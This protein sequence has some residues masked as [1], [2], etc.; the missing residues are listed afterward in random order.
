MNEMDIVRK[1][2][3]LFYMFRKDQLLKK[4]Q[5]SIMKN[6]D[7][8]VLDAIHLLKDGGLIKMNDV[9]S[10]F[11][12][13]PA[14]VSQLMKKYEKKGWIQRV[15]L[16]N[17]RRSVYIQVSEEA[18]VMMKQYEQHMTE[19]LVDFIEELGEEDANALIRILEKALDY[20]KKRQQL[21]EGEHHVE[22]R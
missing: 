17:D 9:S 13:T 3:H 1:L 14:A 2:T 5:K 19:L 22:I 10:Y 12:V 8:M 7:I 4:D 15:E 18:L 21:K 20:S 6:R 16:P 11:N